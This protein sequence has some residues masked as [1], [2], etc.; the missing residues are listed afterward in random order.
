M[1]LPKGFL[2]TVIASRSL[3]WFWPADM[4]KRETPGAIA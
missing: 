3:P 1:P 4:M 2:G